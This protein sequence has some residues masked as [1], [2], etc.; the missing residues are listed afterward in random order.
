VRDGLGSIIAIG[1]ECSIVNV[2]RVPV[3]RHRTVR[4]DMIKRGDSRRHLD[5]TG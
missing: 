4:S 2:G 5:V 1:I 3:W